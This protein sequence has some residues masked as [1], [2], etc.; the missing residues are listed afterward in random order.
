MSTEQTNSKSKKINERVL[1]GG[2]IIAAGVF[3][4]LRNMGFPFPRFLFTW[5]MILIALGLITGVRDQF[6]T[7]SWWILLAVGGFFLFSK[8]FPEFDLDAYFWPVLILAIGVSVLLGSGRIG[9]RRIQNTASTDEGTI[10]SSFIPET[11]AETG[12]QFKEDLVDAAAIFGSVKKN[13]YSKNFK[14]GEVVTVFGGSEINLMHA[15]FTGQVKLEI[16]NIFGG[17]T[18]Y[19]PAH[20]QIRSEAAAILGSIEDKRQ[21]PAAIQTDKVLFLE[22]TVILGGIDI[23]SI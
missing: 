22:G 11:T 12:T 7:N 6:K 10:Q 14:G 4:L 9:K 5:P 15:D 19:V 2:F 13:I 17:T 1:M 3:L 23:K 20:W 8:E 16:V 18:L 21:Q